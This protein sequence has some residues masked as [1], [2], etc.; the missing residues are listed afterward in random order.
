MIKRHDSGSQSGNW[1]IS[2]VTFSMRVLITYS[3]CKVFKLFPSSRL[4]SLV[5]L[6]QHGSGT[7]SCI[8]R[9][10]Y[11]WT[12]QVYII[13]S[14][15]STAQHSAH[16]N[17]K[18]RP[19]TQPNYVETSSLLWRR[20]E[21]CRQKEASRPTG[22]T[23]TRCSWEQW[24]RKVTFTTLSVCVC[25]RYSSIINKCAWNNDETGCKTVTAGKNRSEWCINL[26]L[27]MCKWI[28]PT[29][30]SSNKRLSDHRT[31]RM[32]QRARS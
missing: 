3:W 18:W 7:W 30:H 31:V 11:I 10:N 17:H 21:V 5:K 24:G 1:L 27:K 23:R 8:W 26:L 14:K 15:Q 20:R 9:W 22:C 12:H 6:F 2:L 19:W 16:V 28:Q 4:S 13:H 29:W 25:S 32:C